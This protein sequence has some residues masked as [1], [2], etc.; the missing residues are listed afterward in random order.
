MSKVDALSPHKT[1]INTI[2]KF[3]LTEIPLPPMGSNNDDTIPQASDLIIEN[4][5]F[6][7]EL[8]LSFLNNQEILK[9]N[10]QKEKPNN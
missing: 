4:Q 7:M 9:R 10:L 3:N 6:P 5:T 2:Y 8:N 1:I